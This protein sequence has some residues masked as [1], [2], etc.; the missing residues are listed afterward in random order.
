MRAVSVIS[1]A[2]LVAWFWGCEQAPRGASDSAEYRL[3]SKRTVSLGTF[4]ATGPQLVVADP[5]YDLATVR[6]PGLGAVLTNCQSGTWRAE[7][8]I[9]HFDPPG[10]SL[11]S[12]LR[13]VHSSV[14]D[15]GAL[16]WEPQ[17]HGIGADTGQA[18]VYDLAHFHDHSLVP[19]DIKWTVGQSGPANPD[20]LWYSYC[21]ELF[22]AK[23][24]GGVLL[25]GV[26]TTS[27]KGDGGY[28]YSVTRDAAGKI[29]GIW[30]VFV[31]DSGSG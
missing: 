7:V 12:E 31:D 24:E 22:T 14:L 2:F 26:V 4:E 17:R 30:I 1:L 27:G 10:F 6:I 15:L 13:A 20:D 5:G 16:Q 28:E 19:R 18:G 3:Q 11:T 8:I 25:F 23:P 9:K 21:C 29:V